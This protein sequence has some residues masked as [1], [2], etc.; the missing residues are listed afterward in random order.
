MTPTVRPARTDDAAA[1]AALHAS[2]IGEGFLPTLGPAFLRRLYRRLVLD[3]SSFVLVAEDGGGRVVGFAAVAE[4]LG[5]VY[6]SF[7][8]RDGVVAGIVAAPRLLKGWR[9]VRETLRYPAATTDLPP[10]E[11]LSVA[12]AP[13]A[14]GRGVGR[15]LLAE[16]TAE[17]TR[18]G[19]DGA[20]VVTAATNDPALALY[21]AAG[22]REA[23][24][25]EVHAGTASTV[26][27]WP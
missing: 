27:T 22:F 20:R 1:A 21:R 26:L 24:R 15:A 3:P 10:A 18:R 6:R 11:V 12:V 7:A 8:V 2:E 19:V 4:D 25:L 5:R 23:E 17:L 9:K 16:A 13:E 14:R